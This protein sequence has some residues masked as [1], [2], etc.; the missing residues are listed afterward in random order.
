MQKSLPSDFAYH[1]LK[2]LSEASFLNPSKNYFLD[3]FYK[4]WDFEW[5]QKVYSMIELLLFYKRWGK[6][7]GKKYPGDLFF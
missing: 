7:W 6:T 1:M 2:Y 4:K 3:R 5:T